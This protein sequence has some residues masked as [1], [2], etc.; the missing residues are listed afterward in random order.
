[1][2]FCP[3]IE[4]LP[5]IAFGSM[6]QPSASPRRLL[7]FTL[8]GHATLPPTAPRDMTVKAVDEPSFAIE[9]EDVAAGRALFIGC[10]ICH[11]RDLVSAG[12]MA[13]DLRESFFA[14]DPES[15]WTLLQDGSL[16]QNGMP[17]FDRLTRVE[18]M[19]IYAYIRAGA[20]EAL[21]IRP[22]AQ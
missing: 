15:L 13:P 2:V 6:T 21:G 17:R 4:P 22:A 14:K 7:T 8:D 20:R 18:V 16:M 11:G 10:A 12:A 19:Q 9:E 1:M 5:V 3:H